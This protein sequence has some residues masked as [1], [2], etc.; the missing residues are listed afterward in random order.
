MTTKTSSPFPQQPNLTGELQEAL[1]QI[2]SFSNK[3]LADYHPLLKTIRLFSTFAQNDKAD[4]RKISQAIEVVKKLYPLILEDPT[5]HELVDNTLNTVKKYND[6]VAQIKQNHENAWIS[7]YFSKFDHAEVHPILLPLKNVS[8]YKNLQLAKRITSKLRSNQDANQK[9]SSIALGNAHLETKAMDTVHLKAIR[10]ATPLFHSSQEARCSVKFSP[11]HTVVSDLNS[12]SVELSQKIQT[13]FPG[14]E[15]E[16]HGIMKLSENRQLVIPE[17]FTFKTKF[18]PHSFPHPSQRH[19]WSLAENWIIFFPECQLELTQKQKEIADLLLDPSIFEK[20]KE[21]LEFKRKIFATHLDFFL[22]KHLQLSNAC[23]GKYVSKIH[24]FFAIIKK[25]ELGLDYL[26]EVHQIINE[27][28]I[29]DPLKMI[30][31]KRSNWLQLQRYFETTIAQ[32]QSQSNAN[33]LEQNTID[34]ILEIGQTYKACVENVYVGF[35]TKSHSEVSQ[36]IEAILQ[37]HLHEFHQ[38]VIA[39][40]NSKSIDHIE[41]YQQMKTQLEADIQRFNA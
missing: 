36:K 8:S 3:H 31:L 22:E 16:I 15:V 25:S 1:E 24:D 28:F 40:K 37:T 20:A 34:Y 4:Y 27:K 32:L 7:S 11:I 12:H 30:D 23:V 21:L 33:E 39:L 41:V 5:H 17:N 9:I 2:D 18:Q 13:P 14:E 29:H 35:L 19:G 38:E 26:A 10:F 6:F